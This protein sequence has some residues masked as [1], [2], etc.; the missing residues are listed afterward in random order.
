MCFESPELRSQCLWIWVEVVVD[1]VVVVEVG[2][3]F[4]VCSCTAG[5]RGEVVVVV[6]V[7]AG[8]ERCYGTAWV[9]MSLVSPRRRRR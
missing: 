8:W 6:V 4:G 3:E 1:V 9:Q 5:V 7:C 2:L